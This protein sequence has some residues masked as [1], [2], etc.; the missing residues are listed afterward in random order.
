MIIS[1]LTNPYKKFKK[2]IKRYKKYN[3]SQR[4]SVFQNFDSVYIDKTSR[5]IKV[6]PTAVSRRKSKFGSRQKQSKVITKK[7][8]KHNV[9][10]IIDQNVPSAKKAGR[11]MISN[12][13]YFKRIWIIQSKCLLLTTSHIVMLSLTNFVVNVNKSVS[14]W[15]FVLH[16]LKKFFMESITFCVV[17]KA[18]TWKLW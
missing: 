1:N 11:S 16:S 12:K 8:W 14:I 18:N 9:T 17:Y 4:V 15:R 5:E 6:Q 13:T 2:F 7:I 3:D 10:D